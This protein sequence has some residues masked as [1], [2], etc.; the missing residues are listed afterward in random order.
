MSDSDV[1]DQYMLI[2]ILADF[3]I[4][5]IFHCSPQANDSQSI[6]V[7][8]CLPL[9]LLPSIIPVSAIASNWLFLMTCP[10]NCYLLSH[11]RGLPN[12]SW[13]CWCAGVF[14]IGKLGRWWRSSAAYSVWSWRS[15]VSWRR[16]AGSVTSRPA[17]FIIRRLPSFSALT[18]LSTNTRSSCSKVLTV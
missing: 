10:T 14:L 7:F 5:R 3:S 8:L 2:T 4:S 16:T 11:R 17:T 12:S 9:A 15:A 13:I 6:N 18:A 1:G